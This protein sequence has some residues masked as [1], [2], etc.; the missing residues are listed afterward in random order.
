M[1]DFFCVTPEDALHLT[2]TAYR[3]ENW[4]LARDTLEYFFDIFVAKENAEVF[5]PAN[6]PAAAWWHTV[7]LKT[8]LYSQKDTIAHTVFQRVSDHILKFG[9]PELIEKIN[10]GSHAGDILKCLAQ[11]VDGK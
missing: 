3:E 6:L 5:I 8:N 2:L 7:L 9:S 4:D 11:V 10:N 1:N